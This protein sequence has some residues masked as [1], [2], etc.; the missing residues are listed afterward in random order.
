MELSL[1]F[2]SLS[3]ARPLTLGVFSYNHL[4]T[5]GSP[6]SNPFSQAL[7]QFIQR[8]EEANLALAKFKY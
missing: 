2:P 6:C 1:F 7:S 5:K 4:H 8:T 3:L